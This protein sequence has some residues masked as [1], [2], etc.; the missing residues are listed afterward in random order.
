VVP[1]DPFLVI[2][3][4]HPSLN[5]TLGLF[6]DELR[7]ERGCKGHGPTRGRVPFPELIERLGAPKMMRLGVMHER[8]LIAVAAVDNQG[9]VALA[10]VEEFRRRGIANELVTVL[11][12]RAGLLGYPPLHR[13]TAPPAE[14][15]G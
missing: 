6:L 3:V 14:L 15:A 2:A 10:V 12:E 4:D 7:A 1:P 8:R 11:T 9:A 13:F 5:G